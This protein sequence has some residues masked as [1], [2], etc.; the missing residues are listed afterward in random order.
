MKLSETTGGVY[1]SAYFR[2]MKGDCQHTDVIY[3]ATVKSGT[4]VK[5]YAGST[6]NFKRRRPKP[7]VRT[8]PKLQTQTKFPAPAP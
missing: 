2:P 6:K 8:C 7:Q 5:K 1:V 3:H 4:D